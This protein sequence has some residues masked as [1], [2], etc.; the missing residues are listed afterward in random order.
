MARGLL[1][2]GS[3]AIGFEGGLR[4]ASRCD[5]SNVHACMAPK[6][7]GGRHLAGSRHG[8]HLATRPP[9]GQFASLTSAAAGLIGCIP[10]CV[11]YGSVDHCGRANDDNDSD[12]R[13]GRSSMSNLISGSY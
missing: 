13:T 5:M 1:R 2:H 9:R 3:L 12:V 6:E 8:G 4:T 10:G 11:A 7:R